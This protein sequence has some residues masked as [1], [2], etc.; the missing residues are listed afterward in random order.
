MQQTKKKFYTHEEYFDLEEHSEY[1]YEYYKGD[2]FAMAGGTINDDAI[3]ANLGAELH[4]S[5]P[6]KCRYFTSNMKLQNET[7][8]HFTYPD[9]M[10]VCGDVELYQ[11]RT[12]IISNP[13]VIFEIISKSTEAY[14]RGDKFSSYQ[15]IQS[16]KEYVLINQYK[17]HIDHFCREN[18]KWVLT[19][20]TKLTDSLQLVNIEFKITLEAIYR[21]VEFS[22]S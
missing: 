21:R 20:Y 9:F 1:R 4:F 2:I 19:S 11:D 15:S 8:D 3:A 16:F 17:I 22:G 10:I 18:S 12:D 5:L 13:I 6:E 7:H 14:D